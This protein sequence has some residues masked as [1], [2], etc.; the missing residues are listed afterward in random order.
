MFAQITID[1]NTSTYDQWYYL[2]NIIE[3]KKRNFK[4]KIS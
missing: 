4:L 2:Q 1:K 3:V